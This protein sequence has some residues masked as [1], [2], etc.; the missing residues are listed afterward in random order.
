MCLDKHSDHRLLGM[1]SS[2]PHFFL[3]FS[4]SAA[5]LTPYDILWSPT[6]PLSLRQQPLLRQIDV[7]STQ[8]LSSVPKETQPMWMLLFE[9]A[10]RPAVWQGCRLCACRWGVNSPLGSINLHPDGEFLA[11]VQVAGLTEESRPPQ[12][13]VLGLQVLTAW[14]RSGCGGLR[15]RQLRRPSERAHGRQR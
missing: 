12:P 15:S 3:V 14:L 7:L 4:S 2:P 11:P 8:L 5:L 10:L 6:L 1:S 9:E 13:P